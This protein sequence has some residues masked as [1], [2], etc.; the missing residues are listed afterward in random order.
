M[1]IDVKT[2]FHIDGVKESKIDLVLTNPKPSEKNAT[3]N[4]IPNSTFN[5]TM[6]GKKPHSN[7]STQ[8]QSTISDAIDMAQR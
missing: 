1:S 3:F 8:F 5:K 7:N 4:R 6:D 2:P